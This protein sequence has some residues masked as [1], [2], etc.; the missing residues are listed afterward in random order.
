[1]SIRARLQLTKGGFELQTDLD[2]PAAGVSAVFGPSGA[3]KSLLLRCLAGLETEARGLVSIDGRD[4]QRDRYCLPAHRRSVGFVLQDSPLFPHLSVAGNLDYARK[5]SAPVARPVDY[6]QVVDWL[7]LRGLLSRLPQ[8]LSGG[9]R[10]RV[11]IARAVLRNPSLL[12]MDE[13]LS[14]LDSRSKGQ[15]LGFLQDLLQRLPIPLIYVSHCS[16]EV[17]RLADHL[18]LLEQGRVRAQGPLTELL[19]RL[20][21]SPA[22]AGDAGAVI[23]AQVGD[24]DPEFAL[25]RVVFPGAE[26]FLARTDLIP[27]ARVRLYVQARDVSLVL[28]RPEATSILNLLPARVTGLADAGPAQVTVRLDVQGTPLLARVTRKSAAALKLTPGN[29]LIAQVKSV[30]LLS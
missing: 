2:L 1:M 22:R 20:D 5:R 9:E 27:G 16:D 14:A 4:W 23:A 24:V 6:Q 15:I 26:M 7:G 13:P 28:R 30:A 8:G 19:T 11:A 25:T 10:Q 3:G 21:L 18:V 29:H 17:A 12:L